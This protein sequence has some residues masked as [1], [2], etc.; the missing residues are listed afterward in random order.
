[1][2]EQAGRFGNAL[3]CGAGVVRSSAKAQGVSTLVA[4]NA[5][6]GKVFASVH[7]NLVVFDITVEADRTGDTNSVNVRLG[8][9]F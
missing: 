2:P 9:R 6:Q 3:G 8:F 7:L 5:S 1:V 4:E